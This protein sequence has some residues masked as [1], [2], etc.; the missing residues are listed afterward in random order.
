MGSLVFVD[1]ELISSSPDDL[2]GLF[3]RCPEAGWLFGSTCDTVARGSVVRFQMPSGWAPG[4][5]ILEATGRIV[6][7]EPPHRIVIEHEMPW[8][9][10]VTCTILG[11]G[12]RSRVR[13]VAEISEEALRWLMRRRGVELPGS[14]D[15]FSYPIGLLTSQSGPASVYAAATEELARMAVDEL[16]AD[17][18]VRGRSVRLAVADDA[19]TPAVGAVE[20]RQL[21]EAEGCRVVVTNVTSATFRALEPVAARSGVLLIHSPLNEGGTTGELLFRLGERPRGQVREAIPRLMAESGCRRWYLAGSDYCWPR[22]TNRW[23][24]RTIERTGGMVAGERYE[25][26]GTRNF[27]PLLDAIAASGADLVASTFVG[28]D[29]VAFERQF[30]DAGL[31]DRC[32]TVAFCLDEATREHIGDR[33]AAGLWTVWGYLQQLD[34]PGNAAFLR[35]YRARTGECS[36]P[37]SSLSESVYE[38]VHLVGAAARRARTFEPAEVG[39]Q[40]ATATF[41]G[42]RGRVTVAGPSHQDQALYLAES[43]PGGFLIRDA[44]G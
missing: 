40:L 42:P 29:E 37:V 22:A 27:A 34:T 25:A 44:V 35:R 41:D 17:G 8:R 10:R 4:G 18:G 43:V 24:T 1:E 23:V 16:N 6:A 14:D 12:D 2:F 5:G 3:G 36:P 32:R 33:A 28:G 9:G 11:V 39:R 13:I 31:R 19:T 30:F 26:V 20:L 15:T 7:V 38:A 21:V